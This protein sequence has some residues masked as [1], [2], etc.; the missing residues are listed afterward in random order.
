MKLMET[1][2][3]K[4]GQRYCLAFHP[5]H[6]YRDLQEMGGVRLK[7]L[8]DHTNSVGGSWGNDSWACLV[9][10]DVDIDFET[11]ADNEVGQ[12]GLDNTQSKRALLIPVSVFSSTQIIRLCD[13]LGQNDDYKRYGADEETPSGVEEF[14]G[15]RNST[16]LPG[17]QGL[18]LH[19]SSIEQVEEEEGIQFDNL[20]RPEESEFSDQS[21]EEAN[22]LTGIEVGEEIENIS[23]DLI[24]CEECDKEFNTRRELSTHFTNKHGVQDKSSTTHNKTPRY[25]TEVPRN[26]TT[27]FVC[28]CGF[29]SLQKSASTRHKCR[30]G[31]SVLFY[32]SDCNKPCKNP[33]SL[34][35]HIDSKHKKNGTLSVTA[36]Q[37]LDTTVLP[38][39]NLTNKSIDNSSKTNNSVDSS[40]TNKSVDISRS[41]CQICKKQLMN[42]S[43]LKK[44]MDRVHPNVQ[45][46]PEDQ[47]VSLVA[48]KSVN[49]LNRSCQICKKTL[50]NETNLKKHMD[51]V[52]PHV[53][54]GANS[55]KV[56]SESGIRSLLAKTMD[57]SETVDSSAMGTSGRMEERSQESNFSCNICSK[58]LKNRSN[59]EKHVSRVHSEEVSSAVA[60]EDQANEENE[61]E[62]EV[63]KEKRTTRSSQPAVRRRSISLMRHKGK[64][65][66]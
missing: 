29:S 59:L 18:R 20:T 60:N 51:R 6:N 5:S 62:V 56:L 58:T 63:D 33:G 35:R 43:N 37:D 3:L 1:S 11:T 22:A 30:T 52:H 27:Y 46:V 53:Q 7:D 49:E 31:D 61:A 14:S 55:S 50:M 64:R 32:C 54:D 42:D 66:Y 10:D 17:S 41:A 44:H 13:F 28:N 47:S 15:Y 38:S 36:Y 45:G 9:R 40:K 26:N 19:V 8:K 21:A 57:E 34:K 4:E 39:T 24:S 12:S 65:K 25:I 23:K 48:G 16:Q 2:K